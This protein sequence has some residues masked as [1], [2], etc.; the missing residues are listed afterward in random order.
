MLF[1]S[2]LTGSMSDSTD[3]GDIISVEK[4]KQIQ[5]LFLRGVIILLILLSLEYCLRDSNF[6]YV[7]LCL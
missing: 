7:Y 1:L 4:S 2:N 3:P 5:L 6:K